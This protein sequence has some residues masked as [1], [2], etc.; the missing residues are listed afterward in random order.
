MRPLADLAWYGRQKS[1]DAGGLSP[2]A[3]S[4][5]TVWV[6]LSQ[7]LLQGPPFCCRQFI[8]SRGIAKGYFVNASQSARVWIRLALFLRVRRRLPWLNPL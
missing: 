2:I 8:A 5:L 1:P 3:N 4:A 6:G 7:D